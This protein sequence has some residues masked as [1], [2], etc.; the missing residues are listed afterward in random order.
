[1]YVR[2]VLFVSKLALASVL[3]YMI[4]KALLLPQHPGEIFAPSSAVGARDTGA[5]KMTRPTQTSVKDYSAIIEKNIF[6][7][8]D[9]S[10]SANKSLPDDN[11]GGL[12]ESAE[13]ELALV[14]LGT[15]C[16][17]PAFSRAVIKNT[18]SDVTGLYRPGDL[19]ADAS[20]ESIEKS[21]VILVHNGQRKILRLYTT[22]RDGNA[23]NSQIPAHQTTGKVSENAGIS[24]PS[25]RVSN[26]VRTE[27]GPIEAI[28][29]Q[30]VIE[31]YVAGDQIEGL[32]ITGLESVPLAKDLG[33]KNGDI[34]HAVNGQQVTSKQKAFQVF[35]KART[36]PTMD[37]ELLREGRTKELSFVLR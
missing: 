31:P 19:V 2:K 23:H 27:T 18:Q 29:Q 3:C 6:G 22:Q 37:V 13:R 4:V 8:A 26:E 30:A 34:I 25:N 5:V 10:S 28:L 33:L 1:L 16:G 14:L 35:M 7:S 9:L 20:I 36:Q 24:L 17:S 32:R 11:A 21:E 12:V 15:V